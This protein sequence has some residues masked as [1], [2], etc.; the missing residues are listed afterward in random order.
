M[1]RLITFL[2]VLGLCGQA[3]AVQTLQ[4]WDGKGQTGK[5]PY[6]LQGAEADLSDTY[7]Q[8]DWGD[9][10]SSCC[11]VGSYVLYENPAFNIADNSDQLGYWIISS[12]TSTERVCK[13]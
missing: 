8:G 11:V 7:G 6:T 2:L 12:P 9:K 13:D 3:L 1:N 4:C 5:G 10:I